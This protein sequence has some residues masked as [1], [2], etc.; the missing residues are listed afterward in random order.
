MTITYFDYSVRSRPC[1][2]CQRRV[3]LFCPVCARVGRIS[4]CDMVADSRSPDC[5]PAGVLHIP[6][7]W[8]IS[9]PCVLISAL[10]SVCSPAPTR[11]PSARGY[12]PPVPRADLRSLGCT[13]VRVPHIPQF[14]S[15][16]RLCVL[17][18]PLPSVCGPAPS[19][20]LGRRQPAGA[21]RPSQVC[22]PRRLFKLFF[23][24]ATEG[25]YR[26]CLRARYL[27]LSLRTASFVPRLCR[28]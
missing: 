8:S 10:P 12:C 21:V 9:G 7:Y 11:M 28:E 23:Y 3:C 27:P 17:I 13:P 5:M 6:Q 20:M 22:L 26:A 18:P 4:H 24:R 14:W 1:A 2:S 19:R 16:S 25:G 15:I